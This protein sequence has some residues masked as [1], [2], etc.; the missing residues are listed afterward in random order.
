MVYGQVKRPTC[1]QTGGFGHLS[2]SWGRV[3]LADIIAC[4][5]RLDIVPS[6]LCLRRLFFVQPLEYLPNAFLCDCPIR[7]GRNVSSIYCSYRCFYAYWVWL[8]NCGCQA[9]CSIRSD[10]HS[11]PGSRGGFDRILQALGSPSESITPTQMI[12]CVI[13][14]VSVLNLAGGR[15]VGCGRRGWDAASWLRLDAVVQYAVVLLHSGL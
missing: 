2:H 15:P 9:H 6:T 10:T 14:G 7:L 11:T 3:H 1:S 5:L 13:V 12:C 4:F 8:G